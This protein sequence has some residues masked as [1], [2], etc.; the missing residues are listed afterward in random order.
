MS[1][2][3]QRTKNK[4]LK[5]KKEPQRPPEVRLYIIHGNGEVGILGGELTGKG[6]LSAR[7]LQW[8][9]ENDAKVIAQVQ[10]ENEGLTDQSKGVPPEFLHVEETLDPWAHIV[11]QNQARYEEMFYSWLEDALK[12]PERPQA[13]M[14]IGVGLQPMLQVEEAIIREEYRLSLGA[15]PDRYTNL[16][17]ERARYAKM[18]AF[19]EEHGLWEHYEASKK[20]HNSCA[21]TNLDNSN[22]WLACYDLPK[23]HADGTH[24]PWGEHDVPWG[25]D[26]MKD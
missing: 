14:Q 9:K 15:K 1:A 13:G 12:H 22:G 19:I 6:Q 25:R 7:S 5:K 21:R 18:W 20:T 3:T 11:E 24:E 16:D 23:F 4:R 17:K 8:L 2:V 10:N 26:D